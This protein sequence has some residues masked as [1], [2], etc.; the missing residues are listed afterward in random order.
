MW[1]KISHTFSGSAINENWEALFAMA[2]VV[3]EIGSALAEKLGYAYPTKLEADIRNYLKDLK[4]KPFP[5]MP[6]E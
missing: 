1:D 5:N 4:I 6:K 3:T 2:D